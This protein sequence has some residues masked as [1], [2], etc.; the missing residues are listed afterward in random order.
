MEITSIKVTET[1]VLDKADV[2]FRSSDGAMLANPRVGRIGIQLYRGSELGRPDMDVVRVYRPENEVMDK[3]A[4]ATIAHRPITNDHPPEPVTADNWKK[5]AIGHTG[6]TV[7]RDG[8]FVR[9]P[10]MVSD[11]AAIKDYKNGKKELSLGYTSSI[12]WRAGETPQGEKYDAVQ[13]MIRVNHLALVDAARGGPKLAIGDSVSINQVAVDAAKKLIADGKIERKGALDMSKAQSVLMLASTNGSEKYPF[14]KDGKVYRSA[15]QSIKDQAETNQ[16]AAVAM[17]AGELIQLIDTK[18]EKPKMTEKVT[19]IAVDG[20]SLEMSDIAASVV[21]RRLKG[22]EQ[23]AA[24][25]HSKLAETAARAKKAEDE[26][27]SE[28]EKAKKKMD[29]DAATIDALKKQVT[30]AAITPAKLDQLVKDRA[31]T[32]ARAASVLGDKLVVEGKTDNEIRRQVVD[33]KLG[34]TAKN[35]TDDQVKAAFVAFTADYKPAEDGAANQMRLAFS[36]RPHTAG[37][38]DAAKREAPYQAYDKRLQDAWKNPTG[39]AA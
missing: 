35:Y 14:A 13:T 34:D 3:A 27:A 7:A 30:D 26:L 33:A 11:G 10:I 32:V 31:D 28:K 1:L 4:M 12:E 8:E 17:L 22:L 2:I 15:L 29:E 9:V 38:T 19:T 18:Q 6:D 24:D 5:Y 25:L 37:F 16:E 39:T 20:V 21:L 23:E 36:G